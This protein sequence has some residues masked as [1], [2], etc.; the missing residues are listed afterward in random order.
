MM[1]LAWLRQ[2]ARWLVP[3]V[4]PNPHVKAGQWPEEHRRV[5]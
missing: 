4:R 2:F 1:L 5:L 3:P